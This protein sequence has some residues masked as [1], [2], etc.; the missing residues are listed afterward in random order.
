[1]QSILHVSKI[2]LLKSPAKKICFKLAQIVI[3]QFLFV[4]C[5]EVLSSGIHFRE[6]KKTN[7]YIIIIIQDYMALRNNT[8]KTKGQLAT[9]LT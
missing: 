3:G 5:S 8:I 4:C 9:L 2:S 6:K 7:E 1:M